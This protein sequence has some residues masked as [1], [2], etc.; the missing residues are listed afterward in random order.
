MKE[1]KDLD[2]EDKYYRRKVIG[3]K[4]INNVAYHLVLETYFNKDYL[5]VSI[6]EG[7]TILWSRDMGN[8]S[9]TSETKS[10]RRSILINLAEEFFEKLNKDNI[11]GIDSI[12]IIDN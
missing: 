2:F 10:L 5:K 9:Y 4:F 11:G 12:G 6:E 7:D 1:D 8:V 3:A